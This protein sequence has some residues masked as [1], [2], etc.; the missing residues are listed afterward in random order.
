MSSGL[1]R[2]SSS[3]SAEPEVEAQTAGGMPVG[4]IAVIPG[5]K[6]VEYMPS[7]TH[8]STSAIAAIYYSMDHSSAGHSHAS[9]ASN[10]KD[11]HD[12]L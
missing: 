10:S 6:G 9:L 12:T 2:S 5:A 4:L 7:L 11:S 1:N 3:E 8:S